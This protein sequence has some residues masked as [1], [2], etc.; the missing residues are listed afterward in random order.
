MLLASL[1]IRHP[2]QIVMTSLKV[3]RKCFPSNAWV[4]DTDE[5]QMW[6]S[7]GN[8]ILAEVKDSLP[9]P[10]EFVRIYQPLAKDFGP[11]INGTVDFEPDLTS[12][13][14]SD[15]VSKSDS[16]FEGPNNVREDLKSLLDFSYPVHFGE[17]INIISGKRSAFQGQ[18]VLGVFDSL[19]YGLML[20]SLIGCLIL[21]KSVS[22]Y[23]KVI[24]TSLI[25]YAV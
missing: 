3:G 23:L 18:I 20:A 10:M 19:S 15:G 25:I 4:T 1:A 2:D 5:G 17:T 22:R 11:V 24:H 9:V 21:V 14:V 7:N 6:H 12:K 13:L 16:F 8:F